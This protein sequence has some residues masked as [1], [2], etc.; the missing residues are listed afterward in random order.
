MALPQTIPPE[1][2]EPA[3][4]PL[5]FPSG[6]VGLPT[7]RRFALIVD[8]ETPALALLQSLDEPAISLLVAE[9]PALVPDYVERLGA[10]DRAALAALGLGSSPG[11]GLYCTLTVHETGEITANLA[12]PLVIDHDRRCGTQLVLA[13]SPWPVRYAVGAAAG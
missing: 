9:V 3:G 8:A 11:V 7:W 13:A 4:V 6:L 5:V 1:R 12:G 10:D 2:T